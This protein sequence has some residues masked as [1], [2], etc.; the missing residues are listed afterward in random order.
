VVSTAS[1]GIDAVY[2]LYMLRNAIL[3]VGILAA[4]LAVLIFSGKLPIGNS[5]A[6][7]PQ[8]E[9]VLWGTFPESEMNGI[10]QAFNPQAKTYRVTYRE[11]RQEVF[12]RTLLEA[13]ANGTGP[14]MI[15]APYQIILSQTS[16]LYPFPVT[17]LSET[18]FKNTY[19]DGAAILYNPAGALALPVAMDPMVLFYNRTLFSNRGIANPPTYWDEV[20]SMTPRF[21]LSTAKNTF[22]QS[23][24]AL[25]TPG[26]PYAKDIMMAI[27]GELG[28]VPVLQQYN[29]EGASI[30]T[31]TANTPI[32]SN[33]NV[34]PLATVARFFTQF[35]DPSQSTYT[36]NDFSGN[37]DDNFVAE[38]LAMYI[39]Y[40][41]ELDTLRARNPK[42]EFEMTYLPQTRGY[43]TFSTGMNLY[44]IATLRSSKNPLA[45]LNVEA[46]FAGGSISPSIAASIGAIPALR[47]YATTPGINDV[48]SHSM[49][50]S[51]GWYDAYYAESANLMATMIADIMNGRYGVN[52]AVTLFITRLQDV[53]SPL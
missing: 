11:V 39:G 1:S 17:S 42:G 2:S 30:F 44:G 50:V 43:N 26:T 22:S 21:T 41:S 51:R 37:A 18:V 8:G 52:D 35:S 15:M 10:I 20:V 46:Q 19:V 12:A 48:L 34:S 5:S 45:A 4:L 9:V 29:T 49:L 32:E 28:Q 16:R 53:Y 40:A 24:I 23:A 33:Q 36:W 3:G 38:K 25:G 6:T 27:V 31:V 14:D 13:L 47:A 7:T